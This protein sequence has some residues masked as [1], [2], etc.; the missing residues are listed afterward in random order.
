ML[1]ASPDLAGASGASLCV[2]RRALSPGMTPSRASRNGSV[3]VD[4]KSAQ[5]VLTR[6]RK[7]TLFA[8]VALLVL[9]LRSKRGPGAETSDW[10]PWPF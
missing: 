4:T 2:P 3:D 1:S 5:G 10:E 8:D 9:L 7:R 6:L